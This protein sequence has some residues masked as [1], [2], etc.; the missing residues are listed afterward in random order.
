MSLSLRGDSSVCVEVLYAMPRVLVGYG[1]TMSCVC[2]LTYPCRTCDVTGM[3]G[4]AP[5]MGAGMASAMTNPAPAAEKTDAIV[6]KV[7]DLSSTV[8]SGLQGL[9]AKVDKLLSTSHVPA[10]A[11]GGTLNVAGIIQQMTGVGVWCEG[12]R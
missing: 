11:T 10:T 4:I 12:T 3:S 1:V 8:K 5:G 6:R 9:E 7:D 2:C